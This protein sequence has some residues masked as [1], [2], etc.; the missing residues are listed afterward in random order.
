MFSREG[1][2]VSCACCS[3]KPSPPPPLVPFPCPS[4]SLGFEADRSIAGVNEPVSIAVVARN[5]SSSSVKSM[6]V[7]LLQVCTWYAQGY[8]QTKSRTVASLVVRGL[9]LGDVQWPVVEGNQ[10]GRSDIAV[11][12]EAR[13][14]IQDLLAAGTGTRYDI[15]VPD[16]CLLTMKTDLIEVRH[17]LS[18]RLKT[19]RC[20]S[21]PDL[22]MPFRVQARMAATP[23]A[24][25]VGL[26]SVGGMVRGGSGEEVKVVSVPQSAVSM[27]F[28]NDVPHPSASAKSQSSP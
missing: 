16:G 5:D 3:G 4:L 13:V 23:G 24:T 12:D 25:P 14:Y 20:V 8:R 10:R 9:E 21:S 28:S 26:Q 18:V 11:A 17:L 19:P 6:H 22:F 1:F 2:A 15:L 27:E 7:E